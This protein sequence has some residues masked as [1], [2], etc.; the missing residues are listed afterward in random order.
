MYVPEI[1]NLPDGKRLATW[2]TATTSPTTWPSSSTR[3]RA[4]WTRSMWV[5]FDRYRAGVRKR[6]AVE[7]QWSKAACPEASFSSPRRSGSRTPA[8]QG[9]RV[10]RRIAEKRDGYYLDL[11]LIHQPFGVYYGTYRA[12]EEAY[13]AGKARAIGVSNFYPDRLIDLIQFNEVVRGRSGGNAS[14]PA[15]AGRA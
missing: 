5:P 10:H 11:L 4:C 12:M 8:R 9:A 1:C 6:E 13:K 2:I 3:A 14:L 7:A 15:A